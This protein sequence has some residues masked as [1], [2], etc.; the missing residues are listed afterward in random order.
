MRESLS[1][2][3]VA[4]DVAEPTVRVLGPR[5]LRLVGLVAPMMRELSGTAYQFTA[6]FVVDD[7]ATRALV[8]WGPESWERTVM[9]VVDTG[10]AVPPVEAR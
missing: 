10:R 8:G 2:I 5:A 1:D 7:T 9:R 3:A 4:A 6:P